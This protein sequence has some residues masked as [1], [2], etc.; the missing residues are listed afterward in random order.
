M[1]LGGSWQLIKAIPN[2]EQPCIV[3][4]IGTMKLLLG[5][6]DTANADRLTAREV[7]LTTGAAGTTHTLSAGAVSYLACSSLN[8]DAQPGGWPAFA[9]SDAAD[10]DK[11]SVRYTDNADFSSWPL[12]F[13]SISAGEDAAA[14]NTTRYFVVTTSLYL[15]LAGSTS[16]SLPRYHNLTLSLPHSVCTSLSVPHCHSITC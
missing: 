13:V 9:F 12:D 7:E 15:Y 8:Q 4:V 3:P 14:V 10:G 6:R 2:A 1:L 11:L 16:L 5:Y